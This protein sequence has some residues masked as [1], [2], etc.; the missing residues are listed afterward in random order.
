[1]DNNETR[2]EKA[3]WEPDKNTSCCFEQILEATPHKTVVI[4]RLASHL[5][6]H[7]YKTNKTCGA[8]L[9]IMLPRYI[10]LLTNFRGLSLKVKVAPWKHIFYFIFIHA[11][12]NKQG[13]IHKWVSLVDWLFGFYGIA[14]L[15]GY[16]TP[17]YVYIYIY[18]YI[19]SKISKR[20]LR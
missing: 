18:I 10:N 17:N 15:V 19:Q 7:P 20:I 9:E 16:L 6:N 4:R 8:M 14:T 1:M 13:W 2:R 12:A 3:K 11:L 5:T